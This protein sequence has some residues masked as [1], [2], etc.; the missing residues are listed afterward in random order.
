M[1]TKNLLTYNAK[2]S[3]VE[4]AYFAPVTV[5]PPFYDIYGNT[6]QLSNPP[7]S[8]FYCF[9]SKVDP[10]TD[11]NNPPTPTQDQKYIKQVFKN[12]FVAKQIT[13]N[14][15]SPVIKRVDWTTGVMYDYYRDDIDMFAVDDNGNPI[16]NY[17]VKNQYD[18]V[19]KCLWNAGVPSTVEPYF[20]PGSYGTN[21]IYLGS[22]GY[23]WKYMY[24]IDLGQKTK[25]MNTEW[26]PVPVGANTPN[27]LV[28][29]AGAGNIDVINITNG[30]SGYDLANGV[31]TVTITGDGTGATATVTSAQVVG[32]V[33]K[34]IT[35]TT[36]GTNYTYANVSIT[37]SV[38]SNATAISPTSPIG[39]HSYDPISELGTTHVMYAV[40]FNGSEGEVIPTDI[41]YHQLGIIVNPTTSQLSPLPANG[42]IYKTTTDLV[43]APGFGAFTYDE[44]VYQ[45]DVDNP[46][47]K[48]TVLNFDPAS[49]VIRLINT[50]G[51][52]T[53]NAPVHGKTSVT[54]RTL[55]TYSYPNFTL[56]SGYLSYIENRTGITRSF[57]GIEQFKFVLGY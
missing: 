15:I 14:D 41:T 45:G 18:Q 20:E 11:E 10:W 39:G 37:S 2:I 47:F 9:L 12:M 32:G 22:D 8:T 42:T 16:Y 25:F 38:G 52:L 46:S 7:L 6:T 50:S 29:T 28:S 44:I 24:S 30:G 33:I 40:E 27:P 56:Y 57:D 43:V 17:Y 23:K 34:D 36:P 21:N 3:S 35:V 19:F 51:R 54:T 53:T 48:G 26:L 31:V 1:A 49:N 13:S 5:V 55:L 4:E